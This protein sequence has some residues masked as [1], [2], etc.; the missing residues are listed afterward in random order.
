MKKILVLAALA[1]SVMISAQEKISEGKIISKQTMSTDNEQ[2]QAQL[3]MMGKMETTTLFKGASSRSELDNPMSGNIIT[4]INS[5]EKKMLMLMDNP[6]LGKMYTLEDISLTEEDLKNIKV[7]KGSETKTV[8]GYEC[9]QYITS[10]T[11][12]GVTIDMVMYTTEAI[13]APSQQTAT[14]G[15]KLKGFPLFMVMKMNQM[16]IDMKITTEVT[17]IEKQSVSSDLFNVTPPEGY[18]N[19]KEQ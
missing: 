6:A 19:M 12:D 5:E 16:G 15:G 4:V 18:K 1:F 13:E 8:L 14:L 7:T 17:K 11:K 3:E 10:I 2:V 9:H